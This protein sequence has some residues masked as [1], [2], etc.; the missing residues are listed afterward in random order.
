[1]PLNQMP[2]P[3]TL[4]LVDD[5]ATFSEVLCEHL[6]AR[7]VRTHWFAD[8]EA[9]LCSEAPFAFQFY[10]LDLMLPGVDGLSLLKLL[11]RRS[12]A[13]V[14]VVSGR[15][16]D[17]VFADV[18]S[19]HADMFIAKPV[20]AEQLVLAVAA[21]HRRSAQAQQPLARNWRLSLATSRL[22]SPSGAVISLSQTDAVVL[23]QLL[24]AEDHLASRDSLVAA[25]GMSADDAGNLLN[26]TLYRL[27][28][29]IES[30]TKERAPLQVKSRQ[31]YQFTARLEGV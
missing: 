23:E 19:A 6:R 9:L 28:R 4:A 13:G 5:D 21:V 1:M 20:S 8:S 27:R 12:Q 7:G 25:L 22:T 30:V 26:A 10:L 16:V 24:L 18:M 31:G 29:R 11:R 2:L 3:A 14:V 15:Q 17:E